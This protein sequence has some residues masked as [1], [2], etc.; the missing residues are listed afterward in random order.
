LAGRVERSLQSYGAVRHPRRWAQAQVNKRIAQATPPA[1][2]RPH[3]RRWRKAFPFK[4]RGGAR[5]D[6]GGIA[7]RAEGG[8]AGGHLAGGELAGGEMAEGGL[9]EGGLAEGGLA[10]SGLAGGG[11][12]EGETSG[13]AADEPELAPALVATAVAHRLVPKRS[14]RRRSAH[15]RPEAAPG[16]VARGGAPADA[17]TPEAAEPGAPAGGEDVL[18]RLLEQRPRGGDVRSPVMEDAFAVS[19]RRKRQLGFDSTPEQ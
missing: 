17:T 16:G 15:E 5:G 1:E 12:A 8:L 4:R 19:Q 13:A 11:L 3:G 10:E 6:A 14:A 2:E 7:E 18:A 9:A